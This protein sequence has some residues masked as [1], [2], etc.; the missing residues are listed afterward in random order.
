LKYEYTRD[1][2]RDFILFTYRKIATQVRFEMNTKS[3]R[4]KYKSEM[5]Q[6]MEFLAVEQWEWELGDDDSYTRMSPVKDFKV[7]CDE[8]NNGEEIINANMFLCETFVLFDDSEQYVN[9]S[10]HMA[11]TGVA[12][13]EIQAA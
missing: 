3:L 11:S 7:V 2:V 4:S 1:Q 9:F 12:L 5:E 6:L 8:T 13:D 10:L